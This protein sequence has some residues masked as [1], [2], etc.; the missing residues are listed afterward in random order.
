M[1]LLNTN[2]KIWSIR[3][4][5]E[6]EKVWTS[7]SISSSNVYVISIYALFSNSLSIFLY[8]LSS[9]TIYSLSIIFKYTFFFSFIPFK[10]Y[11]FYSFFIIISRQQ[12][13]EITNSHN[14]NPSHPPPSPP[15]PPWINPEQ[16]KPTAT[17]TVNQLSTTTK[18]ISQQPNIV[19]FQSSKTKELKRKKTQISMNK[20]KSRLRLHMWPPPMAPWTSP[21]VGEP[22]Q[23]PKPSA[24]PPPQADLGSANPPP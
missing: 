17:T 5:N 3:P 4:I 9:S 20:P 21:R 14:P 7:K 23:R 12:L 11:I 13:P 24:N 8:T 18:S 10:Y 16:P 22:R 19:K 1:N 15:T 2:H 6:P